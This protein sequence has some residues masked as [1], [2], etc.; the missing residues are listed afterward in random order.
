VAE[1]ENET[2]VEAP[3]V[4]EAE[5]LHA[6]NEMLQTAEELLGEVNAGAAFSSI[7]MGCKPLNRQKGQRQVYYVELVTDEKK[8]IRIEVYHL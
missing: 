5:V 6:T 8:R 7:E 3:A 2:I 1:L 4:T